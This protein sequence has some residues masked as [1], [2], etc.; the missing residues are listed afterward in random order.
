MMVFCFSLLFGV[1]VSVE[2][3]LLFCCWSSLMFLHAICILSI[4][5][6]E[7]CIMDKILYGDVKVN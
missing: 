1:D 3:I 2:P 7:V 6:F 5:I 4:H